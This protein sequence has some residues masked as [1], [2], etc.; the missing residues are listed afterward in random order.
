MDDR[1]MKHMFPALGMIP[2][3]REVGAEPSTIPV[4]PARMTS[5]P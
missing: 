3:D 4:P 1:K 2:V 5:V